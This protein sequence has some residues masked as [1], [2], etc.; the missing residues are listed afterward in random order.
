MFRKTDPQ[1][2]LLESRF[3]VPP[4]KR[5]RL[6]SSWSQV[7]NVH[8]LPLIDEELFRAAYHEDNGRPNK[9]IRLLTALHLLKEWNDLTDEE[10]L[11]QLEYNIQWHHA[12][13]VTSEEAH[14][15]QKTLH[16]YRVKLMQDGRAESLFNDIAVGL[17]AL[18]GLRWG[19]QRLDSTHVMS[20]IAVLTRLGLF[21]ETV[22][23][24]LRELRGQA[25]A[26]LSSLNAGYRERYLD[27]EGYFADAKKKQARRRLPVVARDLLA[28]VRAFEA[29]EEVRAWESYGLMVRLLDEQCDIVEPDEDGEPASSPRVEVKPQ[30]KVNEGPQPATDNGEGS[31]SS[32]DGDDEPEDEDEGSAA[33]GDD[34]DEQADE[35]DEDGAQDEPPVEP[36]AFEDP[37]LLLKEGKEIS[38]GSLQS[39]HDPDATYGHK[40]K[41]YEVQLA[42]TCEAS[43]PYQILTGISVNGANES[44]Q[45]ATI[46]MVEQLIGK[47]LGPEVMFAD[48]SY[49]SGENIVECAEYGV[50]LQAPV[51]DPNKPAAVDRWAEPV[52][53]IPEASAEPGSAGEEPQGQPPAGEAADHDQDP[54]DPMGLESFRFNAS[55]DTV[56][57]CPAG[58]APV[59]QEIRDAPVP[60]RAVFTKEQCEGCP[61]AAR[62]PT[63]RLKSGDRVLRWRDSK[64]A[65]ATRQR[66]QQESAFKEHYKIRSGIESSAA[67]FKGRHGAKEMRVRG[68]PRVEMMARL[69]AAALNTKRMVQYHIRQLAKA[70]EPDLALAGAMQ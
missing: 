30:A 55:Y 67:E 70:I 6:E 8:V 26:K 20:N 43:N 2:S 3:L 33:D 38:G 56:E 60:Y 19:R 21:T 34:A 65:T 62:C 41:G 35:V 12:L 17:A 7:F 11:D 44:D 51:Q 40:G 50:D 54:D 16:N 48:T 23:K 53:P 5:V 24:F 64:A 1:T 29:D 36:P 59:E 14:T 57:A 66:Q 25:S 37:G 4:S 18:D 68:S 27:R 47:G 45:H 13:G 9:S 63:R 52:E 46:P 42:E 10:V 39:P 22:T 15:C 31:S 49:G 28:L 61:L 69:K 32:S 58:R